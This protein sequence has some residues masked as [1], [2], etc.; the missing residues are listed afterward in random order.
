MLNFFIACN[1]Q[2]YKSCK[3][4]RNVQKYKQKSSPIKS[5]NSSKDSAG[6][7]SSWYFDRI[8]KNKIIINTVQSNV[9]QYSERGRNFPQA[10]Q[11]PVP[12]SSN[13]PCHN[14]QQS[15]CHCSLCTLVQPE[16]GHYHWPQL[17]SI[18]EKHCIDML[19]SFS[20]LPPSLLLLFPFPTL[21]FPPPLSLLLPFP[22]LPFSFPSPSLPFPSPPLSLSFSPSI[23]S[24][25][26][27]LIQRISA[28]AYIL[29]MIT[30]Q[31]S[32]D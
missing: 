24:G 20:S 23:V 12:Q 25:Q 2:K 29:H 21:F 31:R 15:P 1:R 28:L 32:E 22:S 13:L 6:K 19:S 11:D 14:H 30:Q 3:L 5:Q 10:L 4:S 18:E 8:W 27:Q 17:I 26:H 16:A 9:K 7:S